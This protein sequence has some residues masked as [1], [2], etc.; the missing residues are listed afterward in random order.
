MWFSFFSPIVGT[1]SLC[2]DETAGEPILVCAFKENLAL[3]KSNK[4]HSQEVFIM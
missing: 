2:V 4:D 1:C 3:L